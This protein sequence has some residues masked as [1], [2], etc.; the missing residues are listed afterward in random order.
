MKKLIKR[1]PLPLR[2]LP[3]KIAT[4]V[5]GGDLKALGITD[6]ENQ[7]LGR[8]EAARFIGLK[9][10]TLGHVLPHPGHIG[11]RAAS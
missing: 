7:Y 10:Q 3:L 2:P 4:P 6:P 11:R 1:N 5:V 8:K 9:V